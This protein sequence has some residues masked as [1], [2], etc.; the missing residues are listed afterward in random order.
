MLWVDEFFQ[1]GI[2]LGA[3]VLVAQN[4]RAELLNTAID[5]Q[6]HLHL[7]EYMRA[8]IGQERDD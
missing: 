2:Q 5:I 7:H 4:L 3:S 1:L 8:D 6:I